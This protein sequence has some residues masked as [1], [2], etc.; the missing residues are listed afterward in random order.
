METSIGKK[1]NR[2]QYIEYKLIISTLF[3]GENAMKKCLMAS[4]MG[5]I[6][7]LVLSFGVLAIGPEFS[8]DMTM[9]DAKNKVVTGKYFM[10][11]MKMRQEITMDQG[12]S[13]TILR[14]DKKVGWTLLPNNQY[15]EVAVNFDPN[16]PEVNKDMQYDKAVLGNEKVNGYDCQIVQYTFKEKKYGIVVQWIANQLQF[17]VRTQTKDSGGKITSTTDYTNIKQGPQPDSLF[18]IPAGYEKMKLN[19]KLP[20]M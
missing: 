13:I 11:S 16:N 17:A 14:M 8:A 20:G 10:K 15:M 2:R 19:F 4:S 7:A 6:L 12:T 5:L 3:K 1:G 9:K 18:E